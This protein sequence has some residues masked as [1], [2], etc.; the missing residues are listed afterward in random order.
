MILNSSHI[1]AMSGVINH[2]HIL[3]DMIR[4]TNIKLSLLNQS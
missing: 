2:L 3:A 1:Q 4:Q